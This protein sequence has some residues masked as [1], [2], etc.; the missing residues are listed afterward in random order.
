MREHPEKY[1]NGEFKETDLEKFPAGMSRTEWI[2]FLISV[3]KNK[4]L[5]SLKIVEFD[6]Q[7]GLGS[8]FQS[9]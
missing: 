8:T 5:M 1:P 2:S 9:H 3:K 4:K 7:E 6:S